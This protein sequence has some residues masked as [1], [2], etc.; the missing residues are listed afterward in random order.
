MHMY[1]QHYSK[2]EFTA[3][4]DQL[5]DINNDCAQAS[6]L[7]KNIYIMNIHVACMMIGSVHLLLIVCTT[8]A[9]HPPSHPSW[10]KMVLLLCQTVSFNYVCYQVQKHWVI[11]QSCFY[12]LLFRLTNYWIYCNNNILRVMLIKHICVALYSIECDRACVWQ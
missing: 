12:V 1:N 2:T 4:T 11:L 3:I 9:S 10:S 6:G 7:Q 8:N 5:V